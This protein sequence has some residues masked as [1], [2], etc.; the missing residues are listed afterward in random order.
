MNTWEVKVLYYGKITVPKSALTANLDP[1]LV[2]DWPYLG[3]L[4]Q[5]GK[6]N[7]LVD[8][9]ISDS[10]IINGKAWGGYPAQA[11]R[12]DLEKALKDAKVDP[13]EIDTILFTHL[14]ND[15]AA[16]TTL[17]KNA[18]LIFQRD[19]WKTLMDPLP[20]MNVRR[21]YDPALVAELKT[22]NCV[23]V[24]GDFEF[25]DGIK[26]YKTPGHTAGSMSIAVR[27]K[28][29]MQVLTGD[30]FHIFC[31]AFPKQTEIMDMQGKKHKITPAPEVLG[32]FI[33][34]TL[35][36]D[37]YDYYDSSYKIMSI[38][39]EYKPEFLIPGHEPSLLVTGV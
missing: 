18:Q 15:H 4:L 39:G 17:F 20:V 36:Y 14:H 28:K 30:H 6:R 7:I 16:N 34:S 38:V 19:E 12:A 32:P 35:I 29:G 10:F 27:T 2:I 33:P 37:Y 21:D 22:M 11:G 1:N 9:G 25:T 8:T 31:M 24:E 13:L 26:V 23:K 3:F 5:N